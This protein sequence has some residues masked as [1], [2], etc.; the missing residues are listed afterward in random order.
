M[1]ASIDKEVLSKTADVE[2][3]YDLDS[4]AEKTA[5]WGENPTAF[6]ERYFTIHYELDTHV[7]I[8]QP[9]NKLC[10]LGLSAEH[11][12]VKSSDSI[13]CKFF[14][15]SK[16]KGQKVKPDTVIAEITVGEQ[17]YPVRATVFGEILEVNPRVSEDANIIRTH[18][19][20]EG[21]LVIIRPRS[22]DTAVQLKGLVDHDTYH[23]TIKNQS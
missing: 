15:E 7:Y 9:P 10:I 18:A 13:S 6:L 4:W 23:I 21:Y 17:V 20:D 11:A 22:E 3:L 12:I 16:T 14:H 2:D 1:D 5:H 19:L 8:R